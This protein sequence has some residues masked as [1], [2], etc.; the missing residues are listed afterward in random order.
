MSPV[1]KA[2]QSYADRGVFRGFRA[3]PA[4]GGRVAYQFLWLTRKPMSAT[5]DPRTQ[6]L[7]FPALFPGVDQPSALDLKAVIDARRARNQP[8]HKRIDA[9][10]ARLTGAMGRGDFAL[11]VKVRGENHDYAVK[12]ALNVINE[13]FVALHERHPEYLVERFG[14]SAE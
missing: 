12:H 3:T 4:R 8:A 1:T 5:F 11:T 9:R 2:L 6:S 14:I 13:L 10:R 7:K